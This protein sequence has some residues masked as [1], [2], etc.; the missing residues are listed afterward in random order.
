MKKALLFFTLF[1]ALVFAHAE[2]F[3]TNK[4]IANRI[5]SVKGKQIM[6]A[7]RLACKSPLLA[8]FY[9]NRK[10]ALAWVRG[11]VLT[12]SGTA[13]IEAIENA[14][15]DG[16]DP[17]VYHLKQIQKMATELKE[18]DSSVDFDAIAN[19]DL[20]LTDGILLYMNNLVYGWQ[21]P[22]VLYPQW[23]LAQKKVDLLAAAGKM[24]TDDDINK[25][26]QEISPKYPEYIKLRE[27]LAD[28][29][30]VA[31]EDDGWETIDDG[32]TLQ[33]GAKGDRVKILQKRLYI[34]GELSDLKNSGEFDSNLTKAVT[35]YQENN[36]IDDD[37]VVGSQTLRSLNVPV[38]KRI[39]QIELNM[40]RMR[41]LPDSYPDRYAIVDIPDYSL[42]VIEGGKLKL[43]SPVVVGKPNKQTC[44]L[45][46]QISDIEIN[47]FWNVPSSIASKETLPAVQADPKFLANNDIK[48]FK[49][50]DGKYSEIDPD[51]VDWKKIKS[52]NLNY[53]FRQ[54]PG[55][56][57]A[58]GKLKFKFLNRCGIY[59]HDS[60]FPELFDETQRG[61][62]HGCVRV[63]MPVDFATFLLSPNKGWSKD[64]FDAQLA[65]GKQNSVKL[66]K[67]LQLYI[68]Y[69][70]AWY[71]PE[72][73]FVQFRDD[74]YNF[75]KLSLYPV[76]MTKKS[77]QNSEETS[78]PDS[79]QN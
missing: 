18:N 40:D 39:Q 44:V 60:P 45:N 10:N 78:K 26:L 8:Q 43:F 36:G 56:D 38:G 55:D 33:E 77:V 4:Q 46:S 48:V 22:K 6:C 74:I 51:K 50:K 57:N 66:S 70:T 65:L 75:D 5:G 1:L 52:S 21:N 42:T 14:N 25:T 71:D 19:L 62:S 32:E 67:P 58:M 68:V 13:L 61:F 31:V 17:R 59:L 49:L 64:A 11:G 41:F 12:S 76:Y 27:K 37:G 69:L 30:K 23:P 79:L 72:E 35:L 16:L 34:S 20:T 63:G 47:P 29:F 24:V 28:Y 9:T 54:N 3:V 15:L 73:D 53:R 7:Q 2:E